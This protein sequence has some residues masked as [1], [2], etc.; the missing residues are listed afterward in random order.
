MGLTYA[1]QLEGGR[2]PTIRRFRPPSGFSGVAAGTAA[3]GDRQAPG[4]CYGPADF[5]AGGR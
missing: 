1:S 3:P 2:P 5:D 4:G